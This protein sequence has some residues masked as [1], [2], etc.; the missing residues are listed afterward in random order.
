MVDGK[1]YSRESKRGLRSLQLGEKKSIKS[2]VPARTYG[3]AI[4][5]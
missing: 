1:A 2:K 5:T 3:Y 4:T